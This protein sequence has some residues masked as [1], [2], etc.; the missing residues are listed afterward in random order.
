M[1]FS[2]L[3]IAGL[4]AWTTFATPLLGSFFGSKADLSGRDVN[5]AG[6]NQLPTASV[7]ESNLLA[8]LLTKWTVSP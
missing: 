1:L 4:G 8:C 2:A 3:A 5:E 6:L 7:L